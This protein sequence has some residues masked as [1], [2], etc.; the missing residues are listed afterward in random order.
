[1]LILKMTS[2]KCSFPAWPLSQRPREATSRFV[3]RYIL[4]CAANVLKF[5]PIIYFDKTNVKL[6]ECF[7]F[8]VKW[9]HDLMVI[10]SNVFIHCV[11]LNVHTVDVKMSCKG[12]FWWKEMHPAVSWTR[13]MWCINKLVSQAR[14][15]T[16]HWLNGG[17]Y[18][19]LE[20]LCRS[21][22]IRLNDNKRRVNNVGL[23]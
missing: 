22:D 5:Q 13:H 11:L 12:S 6:F 9:K 7:C 16:N 23:S 17:F 19:K 2:W 20:I 3:L 1:M 8:W 14:F 4:T 18:L 15:S 21:W 10:Y